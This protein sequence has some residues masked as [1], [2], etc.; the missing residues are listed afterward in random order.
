MLNLTT[1][2]ST[3]KVLLL[4]FILTPSFANHHHLRHFYSQDVISLEHDNSG[5]IPIRRENVTMYHV[6]PSYFVPSNIG[7]MNLAD[8][9][10]DNVR[11]MT[12]TMVVVIYFTIYSSVSLY[13][14]VPTMMVLQ[15]PLG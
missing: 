6:L 3:Q 5:I 11:T 14:R 1:S 13:L 15:S 9:R 2:T 8:L 10:G 12:I 4:L 7:N